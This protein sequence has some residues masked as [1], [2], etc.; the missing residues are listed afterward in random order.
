[1]IGFS[2]SNYFYVM[3]FYFV[4]TYLLKAFFI[5][6][7]QSN[8][9][10]QQRLHSKRYDWLHCLC[11]FSII[12]HNGTGI[13]ISGSLLRPRTQIPPCLTNHKYIFP[14]GKILFLKI[15][16]MLSTIPL[17]RFSVWYSLF[18]LKIKNILQCQFLSQPKKWDIIK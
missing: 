8:L 5:P 13:Y 9:L 6:C 15:A 17:N 3:G 4:R 11:N 12:P 7:R 14:L 16:H 18:Q 10:I 1:M 2:G